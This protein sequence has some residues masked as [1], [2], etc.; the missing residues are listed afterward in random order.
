MARNT[1]SKKSA[2]RKPEAKKPEAKPG[3]DAVGFIALELARPLVVPGDVVRL[4]SECGVRMTIERVGKD[5]FGVPSARCAWLT[6]DGRAEH[7]TFALAAL[8]RVS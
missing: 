8:V 1:E 5:D 2:D 7:N 3:P 4:A 6:S